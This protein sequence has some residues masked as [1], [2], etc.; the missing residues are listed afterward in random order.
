MKNWKQVCKKL[1]YPPFWLICLLTVLSAAA[2]ILV[3]VQ[4]WR[5]GPLTYAVYALSAYTL[6]I[7]CIFLTRTLPGWYGKGKQKL[8]SHPL[9]GRY[10]TDAAFRVQVSLYISLAITLAFSALKLVS[11]IF[12]ASFWM[13]AVAIYYILL[14]VLRFILLR[15][16]QRGTDTQSLLHEYRRYRLCGGILLILNLSLSGIVFQMV[17]QDKSYNYPGTLIFVAALYT[18]YSVT[19]SLIDIVRYR[20]Y[21]SPVLSAAKAIRLAAALVSLLSL[22]TAMLTRFG[23][24]EVFRRLMTA[25]TG[26]GVCMIVLGISVYMIVRATKK[27]HMLNTD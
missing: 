9:G 13:G 16:M 10:L 6:A 3:F 23:D 14:S 21:Q 19:V 12:Y 27:I 25:S 4:Q 11:G 5:D 22:E 17:W 8:S 1:I 26:A 15:Y 20:K 24:D 18:F 2:L 7:L